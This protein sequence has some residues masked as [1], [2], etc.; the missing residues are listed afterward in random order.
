MENISK[1]ILDL[2]WRQ[3]V[4]YCPPCNFE[5]HSKCISKILREFDKNETECPPSCTTETYHERQIRY[6]VRA[7]NVD[8]HLSLIINFAGKGRTYYY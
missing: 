4:D 1:V 8:T 5:Q 6:A 2:Q 7:D 3:K